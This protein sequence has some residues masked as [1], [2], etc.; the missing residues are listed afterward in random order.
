MSLQKINPQ[1][2]LDKPSAAPAGFLKKQRCG[3][4]QTPLEGRGRSKSAPC[5]L[6]PVVSNVTLPLGLHDK[7][8][9]PFFIE[10]QASSSGFHSRGQRNVARN[11]KGR[12][13]FGGF[14]QLTPRVYVVLTGVGGRQFIRCRKSISCT[15]HENS[16]RGQVRPWEP[17]RY[18]RDLQKVLFL[19]RY[20]PQVPDRS[21]FRRR[22]P[23]GRRFIDDQ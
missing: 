10:K 22:S 23:Q 18:S 6:L 15:S 13:S 11:D 2:A 9:M 16:G 5:C 12:H 4:Q 19:E 1:P 7:I 3:T 8:P 21:H 17:H 20:H 14:M